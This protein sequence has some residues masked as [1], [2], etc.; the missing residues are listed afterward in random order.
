MKGKDSP[1]LS[2]VSIQGLAQSLPANSALGLQAKWPSA[3]CLPS[4]ESLCLCRVGV[5]P[6]RIWV[7]RWQEGFLVPRPVLIQKT[8]SPFPPLNAL[9]NISFGGKCFQKFEE[10]HLYFR[11]VYSLRNYLKSAETVLSPW[12]CGGE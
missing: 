1:S 11:Y 3:C 8:G 2:P 6:T 12:R 10:Y 7:L 9:L 5:S 4:P